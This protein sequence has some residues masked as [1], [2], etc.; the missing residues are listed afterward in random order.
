MKIWRCGGF[1]AP[2]RA[3]VMH[4]WI[5]GKGSNW[6]TPVPH[7]PHWISHNKNSTASVAKTTSVFG[8]SPRVV[9]KITNHSVFSSH[10]SLV[11]VKAF[12]CPTLIQ[13]C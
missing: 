4:A 12:L 10:F 9:A 7:T 2:A 13:C 3:N 8:T 11:V 1:V 6:I 5:P